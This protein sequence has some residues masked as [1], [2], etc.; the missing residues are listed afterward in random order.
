MPID[1]MSLDDR[2]T[3]LENRIKTNFFEVEKRFA[4]LSAKE[5]AA[6]P[7]GIE[8]RLQEME[9]LILLIQLEN[10]KIKER[11]GT[12]ETPA[13]QPSEATERISRLESIVK[14]GASP[15][16]IEERLVSLE[17]KLSEQLKEGMDSRL[18]KTESDIKDL[19]VQSGRMGSR[20]VEENISKINSA[21]LELD[22][23][24][25]RFRS[26]KDDIE[27]SLTERK[28]LFSRLDQV[29]I[30]VEKASAYF[31]KMKTSEEKTNAVAE[32]IES[33][34]EGIDT[35]IRSG[36]E[37]V[38][39]LKRDME[40]RL[41]ATEEK[42]KSRLEK[43]DATMESLDIKSRGVNEKITE[44]E[45]IGKDLVDVAAIKTGLEEHGLRF[46]SVEKNLSTI[47]KRI[48]DIHKIKQEMD[49]ELSVRASLEKRMEDITAKLHTLK[50]V[51]PQLDEEYTIIQ[52]LESRLQDVI[53]E[54]A[55]IRSAKTEIEKA[56]NAGLASM[57]EKIKSVHL[58]ESINALTASLE[59]KSKEYGT[60]I[61]E[62]LSAFD[63]KIVDVQQ[64][65][66]ALKEP[67]IHAREEIE[68][69]AQEKADEFAAGVEDLKQA[70]HLEEIRNVRSEIA[71]HRKVIQNLKADLEIAATRFFTTNLEE[72]AR[73]LDKKFPGFVSREEYARH[74]TEVSRRL[75]TVEAPDLSPLASRVGDLERR[76][77]DVH[78][79]M[80]NL[81]R[82]MPIVVE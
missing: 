51:G 63:K 10:T 15:A 44:L 9:D 18:A 22:S 50:D 3:R 49:E 2:L 73:T 41:A 71:E 42:F 58:E 70:L 56:V 24:I 1:L 81:V 25:A 16:N 27:K 82:T 35:K 8:E 26:L 11:L 78:A 29:E 68:K 60:I 61:E 31:T 57:D 72:F 13:T 76:L 52:G 54:M 7:T 14:S 45:S 77:G 66:E 47:N 20:E 4:D 55:N 6:E 40:N 46:A 32:K 62:Q 36:F 33:I 17:Q 69:A 21:R 75:K 67:A 30:N 48:S 79:S 37:K 28:D 5:G 74:M 59:N 23:S 39:L 12:Q 43:L 34:S 19:R 38:E 80:Q 53:S 65:I 64:T